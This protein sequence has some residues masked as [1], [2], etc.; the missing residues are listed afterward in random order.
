MTKK[1][2]NVVH[3][4]FTK[5][6]S[7]TFSLPVARKSHLPVKI[8]GIL[9]KLVHFIRKLHADGEPDGMSPLGRRNL[10]PIRDRLDG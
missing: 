8:H 3:T 10:F 5:S 7:L 1:N 4:W 2:Q 6:V 9:K